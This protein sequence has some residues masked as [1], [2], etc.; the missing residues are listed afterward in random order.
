MVIGI[1]S[2]LPEKGVKEEEINRSQ[3]WIHV[4]DKVPWSLLRG[5]FQEP[6]N[7]VS[8]QEFNY[9]TYT[10]KSEPNTHNPI[11]EIDC[12]HGLQELLHPY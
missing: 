4:G 11:N 5:V 9:T 1:V 8:L 7:Q 3:L 2:G 6:A 10:V 12:P